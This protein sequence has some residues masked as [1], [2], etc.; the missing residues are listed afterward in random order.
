MRET[1]RET[2][3]QRQTDRIGGRVASDRE[4]EREREG[5][6]RERR[7]DAD[8]DSDMIIILGQYCYFIKMGITVT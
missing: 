2:E 8:Y 7:K 5:G 3:L 1:S 4:R 6:G